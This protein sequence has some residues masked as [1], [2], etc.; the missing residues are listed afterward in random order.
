MSAA[1][2]FLPSRRKPDREADSIASEHG[3]R[4]SLPQFRAVAEP[5]AAFLCR[6]AESCSVGNR[7]GLGM[8]GAFEG[9]R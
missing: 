3:G 2:T 5:N 1:P 4:D 9:E 8:L 6:L 7:L